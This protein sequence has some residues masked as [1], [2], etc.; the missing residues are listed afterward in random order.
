MCVGKGGRVNTASTKRKLTTIMAADVVGYSRL[1]AADDAAA[2][3]RLHA[4]RDIITPLVERHDG[5]MFGEA[6]D[7]MMAEFPSAVE[8]VQCALEIQKAI[9]ERNAGVPPET[10]MHFRIGIDIG[11]VIVEGE[12]LYGD[13]VN[14]AARLQD[15]AEAGG[16]ALSGAAHDQI[17]NKISIDV[18]SHGPRSLKNIPNP[19]HVFRVRMSPGMR[20]VV[21]PPA[22]RGGMSWRRRALAGAAGV[23]LLIAGF[24][25]WDVWVGPNSQLRVFMAQAAQPVPT[26]PSIIVMPFL[27]A[28]E[29]EDQEFFCLGMAED[30]MTSLTKVKGLFVVGRDSALSFK[31]KSVPARQ[32]GRE[33]GVRYVLQGSVRRA[34]NRVRVS[35]YLVDAA[36]E[37]TV[38]AARYDRELGDTFAIQDDISGRITQALSVSFQPGERDSLRQIAQVPS[39]Y[40]RFVEARQKLYPPSPRNLA[41]AKDLFE[42]V[43]QQDPSFAGGHGGLA[44]VNALWVVNNFD[45]TPIAF[46]KGPNL[47]REAKLTMAA[48]AANT[49]LKIDPRATTAMHALAYAELMDHHFDDAVALA[50]RAYDTQPGDAFMAGTLGIFLIYAGRPQ[51]AMTPL[52]RALDRERVAIYRSRAAFWMLIGAYDAGDYKAAQEAVAAMH[53]PSNPAP[54][55]ST[56]CRMYSA[57]VNLRLAEKAAPEDRRKLEDE[58]IRLTQD[59]DK[60]DRQFRQ[61]LAPW[62]ERFATGNRSDGLRYDVDRLYKLAGIS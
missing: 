4:M 30:I 31:G 25:G 32:V 24:V 10:A 61:K 1:M 23:V 54:C 7:S 50:Q 48:N 36:T 44:F 12:N 27:N 21:L 11:E 53:V 59:V 62:L 43:V 8:A 35:T 57:A 26:M 46:G 5:R 15:I 20:P 16:V 18:V 13:G 22:A 9:A 19:V 37:Q 47:T 40:D 41:A 39:S 2:V 28:S 58:A 60:A 38:W 56:Y 52:N 3:R 49:A 33:L 55:V 45:A 34:D 51:E 6:G 42:E 14:I 29:N 17:K